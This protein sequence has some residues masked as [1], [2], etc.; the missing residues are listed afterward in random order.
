MA[1]TKTANKY[2]AQDFAN[3][4]SGLG[5][6]ANKVAWLVAQVAHETADFKSKLLYD[7]NNASGIVFTGRKTQKNATKGRPLPE[8]P[9]YNYAMFATIKDWAI[10]YLRVLNLRNKPIAANTPDEFI[11]RLKANGYFTANIDAY[12]KSFLKYLAKYGKVAAPIAGTLVLLIA[13]GW[14]IFSK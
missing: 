12:K 5:V 6:P 2:T 3:I 11:N 14:L 8:A 9:Q 7:H 4:F 10:D 13:V 1:T